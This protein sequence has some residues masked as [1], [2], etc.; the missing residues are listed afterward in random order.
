MST[1]AIVQAL[2]LDPPPVKAGS[3]RRIVLWQRRDDTGLERCETVWDRTRLLAASGVALTVADGKPASA[4]YE[5]RLDLVAWKQWVRLQIALDGA[6]RRL[7]IASIGGDQWIV[8][9]A[10]E[11]MPTITTDG[12]EPGATDIDLAFTP[13]TNTLAIHRLGLAV[14]EHGDVVAAW[15]RFPELTVARLPQRYTR[16]S[17]STYH[18]LSPTN[19]FEA[20]IEVDDLN[21]VVRYGDLWERVAVSDGD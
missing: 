20:E 18:Y 16:L 5:L 15:L 10:R 19:D 21:L 3:K 14:G 13:L 11:G 4:T 9:R 2:D 17:E 7:I 6:D 12:R 8:Q 1:N